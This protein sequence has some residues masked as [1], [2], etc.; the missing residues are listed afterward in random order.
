MCV[1]LSVSVCVTLQQEWTWY[2]SWMG[3]REGSS[4]SL[5]AG[6]AAELGGPFEGGS[7]EE[8]VL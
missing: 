3:V 7:G 1:V 8:E 4:S 2:C 5:P 6:G